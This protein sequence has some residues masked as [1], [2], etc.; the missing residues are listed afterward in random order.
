M[1][2]RINDHSQN[3]MIVGTNSGSEL[4]KDGRHD[5]PEPLRRRIGQI[6]RT[7][8]IEFENSDLDP[9]I[10]R[11]VAQTVEELKRDDELLGKLACTEP[12]AAALL[13][14]QAWQLRDER[15]DGRIT[16]SVGRGGRI[17]YSKSDLLRYLENRRWRSKG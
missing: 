11:I 15:R 8:K 13:S 17:L 6:S 3:A 5:E 16:A 14:L 4:N 9:L 1:L 10:R 2:I 7:M 12:E